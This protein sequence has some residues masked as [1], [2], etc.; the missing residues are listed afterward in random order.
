MRRKCGITLE[1]KRLRRGGMILSGMNKSE[2]IGTFYP[3]I[4]M[5][6]KRRKKR[7]TTE[8]PSIRSLKERAVGVFRRRA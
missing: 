3:A 1:H 6:P 7:K 2:D 8:A 4:R 5:Q